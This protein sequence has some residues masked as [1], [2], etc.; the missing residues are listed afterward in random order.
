MMHPA[1]SPKRFLPVTLFVVCTLGCLAW[2][3]LFDPATIDA[4]LPCPFHAATGW[5]CPGCGTQRAVH[6]LLHGHARAAWEANP[7]V[8]LILPLFT[9][10]VMQWYIRDVLRIPIRMIRFPAWLIAVTC[11]LIV[12]YWIVRNLPEGGH[13][14]PTTEIRIE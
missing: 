13:R 1:D 6:Q 7:L 14:P 11:I 5:D 3:Y 2:F 4:F 9:L 8:I 12:V 10:A